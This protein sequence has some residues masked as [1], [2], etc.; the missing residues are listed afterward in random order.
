MTILGHMLQNVTI[1]VVNNGS[2]EANDL[3][4]R[5]RANRIREFVLKHVS[6]HPRDIVTVAAKKFSVTRQSVS[7]HLGRLVEEGLLEASGNT[8]SREYALRFFVDQV[9]EINNVSESEEDQVWRVSVRPHLDDLSPNLLEICAY[10]FTEMFNNVIDHSDSTLARV[11]V[12]RN[13]EETRILIWDNGVGIFAKL[14]KAFQ[15]SDPRDALLELSKGKFTSDPGKHTGEGIFFT[16]RMFDEFTIYSDQLMFAR[17]NLED[18]WII[19]VENNDTP[20]GTVIEL[21]IRTD[22]TRTQKQI[23]DEYAGADGDYS[24]TKT[25]VPVSLARYGEEQL[26]SRSQAKRLLARFEEFDVI[27][28]DFKGIGSIGQAFADEVFRV[29]VGEH[30]DIHIAP[31][32]MSEAV[33]RMMMR[34]NSALSDP[35]KS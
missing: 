33:E 32:N 30:P 22:T 12:K 31:V 34:A 11:D 14:Q 4:R 6:G 28:L 3:G 16:S 35:P 23:F 7:R 20:R 19:E 26:I 18:D 8:R 15:L 5:D 9:V 25:H 27:F 10:G 17:S 24:F 2:E 21:V 29:F 13:A 1:M